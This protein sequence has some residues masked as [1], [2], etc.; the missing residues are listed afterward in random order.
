MAS[1]INSA[2]NVH[3]PEGDD[4]TII[5]EPGRFYAAKAFTLCCTVMAKTKCPA[6]RIVKDNDNKENGYMY[7]INDG[8]Y[9]SFNCLI[10]DHGVADPKTLFEVSLFTNKIKLICLHFRITT[11]KHGH[12]YGGQHATV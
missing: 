9:G 1:V 5:A 8:V 4:V 7:Y 2:L 10:Y 12:Q 6:A 11:P 3:F